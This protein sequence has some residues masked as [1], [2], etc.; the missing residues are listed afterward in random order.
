MDSST[1]ERGKERGCEY[2][3]VCVCNLRHVIVSLLRELRLCILHLN[4][5]HSASLKI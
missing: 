5:V 1:G 2:V 3:Y 4:Y